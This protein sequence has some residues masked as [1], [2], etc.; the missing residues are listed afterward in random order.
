MRDL[1]LLKLCTVVAVILDLKST[2]KLNF[3]KDHPMITG[4]HVQF[5]IIKILDSEKNHSF[6]FP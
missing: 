2:Q 4:I 3:V 1:T 6:I 5:G